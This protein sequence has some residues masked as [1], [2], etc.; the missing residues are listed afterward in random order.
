MAAKIVTRSVENF[1]VLGD[2]N[3]IES[4]VFWAYVVVFVLLGMMPRGLC[5]T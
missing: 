3:L 5:A 1:M 2:R 4:A